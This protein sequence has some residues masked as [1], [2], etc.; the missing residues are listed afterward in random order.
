M[1]SVGTAGVEAINKQI[2]SLVRIMGSYHIETLRMKLVMYQWIHLKSHNSAM[3]R[4]TVQTRRFDEVAA[5]I[6]GTFRI[7][8]EQ[9][10]TFCSSVPSSVLSEQ[11][12]LTTIGLQA[13]CETVVEVGEK[14]KRTPYTLIR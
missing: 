7:S 3:Y 6:A 5:A 8:D 1:Q 14:F 11:R 4:S 10:R 13:R 2:N 9:W 12:V